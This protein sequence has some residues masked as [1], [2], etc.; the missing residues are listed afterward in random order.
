METVESYELSQFTIYAKRKESGKIEIGH[1]GYIRIF[2]SWPDSMTFRTLF[3]VYNLEFVRKDGK[4]Y[5]NT[6]NIPE[7]AGREQGVYM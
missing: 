3:G 4:E 7:E 1:S 6:D 2:D 5:Y